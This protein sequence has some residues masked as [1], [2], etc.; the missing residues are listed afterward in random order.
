MWRDL[1]IGLSLANLCYLRIWSELLTYRRD[2]LYFMLHPPAPPS[3]AAVISNVLLLGAALG[4]G[5]HWVRTRGSERSMTWIR[6]AFLLLLA[7]PL[8]ALRSVLGSRVPQL[9]FLRSPLFEIIGQRGVVLLAIGVAVAGLVLIAFWYKRL[10]HWAAVVLVALFPFVPVTVFQAGWR[11]ANYDASGMQA[12]PPA[13]PPTERAAGRLLWVVFDEWDQ[14]LTFVDRDSTL[15]LPELDRFRAEALYAANVYPPGA[16]TLFSMSAYVTGRVV[17]HAV[18]DGPN[19][20][21]VNYGD[22]EQRARWSA[23]PNVFQHAQK[24]GF[25]TE[26]AGWYHPYCRVIGSS[27]NACDWREMAMQHNSMGDTFTELLPNQTRS[28]FETTLFSVFGQSLAGRHQ[29]RAYQDLFSQ[30]LRAAGDR[31]IG[32]ALLHLPIPHAPHVYD[33]TTGT[34]TKRNSPIRAYLDSLALTDRSVGELRR[35]LEAS[36]LWDSTTILLT[37]D[38]AYREASEVDG[39]SDKRV[40]FLLKLAG[41]RGGL[42]FSGTFNAVLA[43]DL[44]LAILR[45]EVTTADAASVWLESRRATV[46]VP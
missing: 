40:P 34:F 28:L 7:L 43:H 16:E 2:D 33:M 14:R 29:V 32:F 27:I 12:K 18:V 26:L 41:Q 4:F 37:S 39:K 24:L 19:E 23:Q 8:N 36:G 31:E 13:V 35:A 45:R 42:E 15:Q 9:F 21:L 25:R 1:A 5:A 6:R 44:V 11:I 3:Y 20:L 38:H 46:A 30:S 10:S 22:G 17:S